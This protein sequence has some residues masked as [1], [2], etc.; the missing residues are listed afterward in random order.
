MLNGKYFC[1]GKYVLCGNAVLSAYPNYTAFFP[2]KASGAEKVS[3]SATRS[4]ISM[5]YAIAERAEFSGNSASEAGGQAERKIHIP[6]WIPFFRL[7]IPWRFLSLI[8]EHRIH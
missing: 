6:M 8:A 5:T 2:G 4:Y 1:T 3:H 7:V